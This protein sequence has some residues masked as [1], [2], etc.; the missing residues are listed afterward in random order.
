[1][2]Q[3][4]QVVFD[5]AICGVPERRA[6]ATNVILVPVLQSPNPGAPRTKCGEQQ[7]ALLKRLTRETQHCYLSRAHYAQ[8]RRWGTYSKRWGLQLWMDTG[9]LCT[10]GIRAFGLRL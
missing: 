10:L 2:T 6:Q 4:R 1:M 8:G 7:Q 5:P 9:E 3:G